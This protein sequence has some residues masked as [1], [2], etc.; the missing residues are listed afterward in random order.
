MQNCIWNISFVLELRRIIQISEG[1]LGAKHQAIF[2]RSEK[3]HPY[4][5]QIAR[6]LSWRFIIPLRA[7][8]LSNLAFPRLRNL[9]LAG[10]RGLRMPDV[11]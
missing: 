6:Q 2:L 5:K 9:I 3:C 11:L 4:A 10:K 1:H 7:G 8:R